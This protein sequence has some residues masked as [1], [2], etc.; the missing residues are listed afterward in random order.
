MPLAT[1]KEAAVVDFSRSAVRVIIEIIC[2]TPCVNFFL[3]S[4]LIPVE[5]I[6]G[7][8][9]RWFLLYCLGH[10]FIGKTSENEESKTKQ[11]NNNSIVITLFF[12]EREMS[13][14]VIVS[15]SL[16]LGR[17]KRILPTGK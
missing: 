8:S 14:N 3:M 2:A 11:K 1:R 12:R 6:F 13:T 4:F 16:S 5:I 15:L 7:I 9:H 10:R 17:Q